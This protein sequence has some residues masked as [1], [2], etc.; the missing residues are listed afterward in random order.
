MTSIR[1]RPFRLPALA[2]AALLALAGCSSGDA[3]AQVDPPPAPP[4]DLAQLCAALHRELPAEVAGEDRLDPEPASELTAAWGGAAIVLRCAVPRPPEMD[5]PK[6]DG[7]D[8]DGVGW[9]VQ[10]L[11]DGASRFTTTYRKAYVEVTVAAR[12]EGDGAVG[13]LT[14]FTAPVK[15]SVP[16]TL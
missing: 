7:V 9:L 16:S 11:P 8:V 3:R 4:A 6:S 5:D 13:A 2:A 15:K 12:V 10:R 1:R 14:D